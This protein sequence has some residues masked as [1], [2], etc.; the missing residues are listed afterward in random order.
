[1]NALVR[2]LWRVCAA[3][4]LAEA[5]AADVVKPALVEISVHRE[6]HV[7]VALRVSI[8]A[9]LTGI[10]GRYRNTRDAPNAAAYDALR[11]LDAAALRAEYQPWAPQLERSIALLF[12]GRRV[13]LTVTATDIPAAGYTK[14]PRISLIRLRGKAP[15][16]ASELTWYYP[17]RFGDNVVRVRQID[18]ARQQWHWSRHQWIRA[19]RP[20]EPFSLSAVYAQRPWHEVVRN[21]VVTGFEH[22]VPM[23]VDHIL[24]ILG[25]YLFSARLRPLLWQIT[26][27]T[28]AHTVT[29][30]LSM[31]GYVELPARLVEPLIALSIA[32]VGFE[33]VWAAR[34]AQWDGAVRYR[35]RLPLVF[36][37][38]LLHGL[39]FAD[40]LRDFGMPANDFLSALIAFNV[41]VE[42]GQLAV[43]SAAFLLTGLWLRARAAYRR[44][45]VI[46]GSL[47]IGLAGVLWVF[48][49]IEF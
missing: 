3:V 11:V 9:L 16:F 17:L 10:N 43:V 18:A 47:A 32:Y 27:F 6:G 4:L 23:G 2:M 45:I 25:I 38:G 36:A 15:K 42:I 28:A 41:G 31:A 12:D 48:D 22:I 7:E 35:F 40:A 26:M 37:V 19:D 13:P 49:R 44:V 24:F 20:S 33:N 39:G 5:A 8:E 14:V 30:G 29:L 34:R 1:M 21:Y 46:P